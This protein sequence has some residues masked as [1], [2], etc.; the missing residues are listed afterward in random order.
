MTD[1][2][3]PEIKAEAK[4]ELKRDRKAP[5]RGRQAGRRNQKPEIGRA[6]V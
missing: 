2:Q 5:A 3:T 4:P 1:K 6:H